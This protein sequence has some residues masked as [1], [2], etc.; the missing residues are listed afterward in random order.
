MI[1]LSYFSLIVMTALVSCANITEPK[2]SKVLMVSFD[3]MRADKFDL[4]LKD[5]PNS[6]FKKFADKGAK[7]KYMIPSFPTVTFPN[8]W[9]LVTGLY[10]ESHGKKKV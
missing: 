8:H 6:N 3:G 9:T 2:K 10:P 5:N 7:A 1:F 4:F